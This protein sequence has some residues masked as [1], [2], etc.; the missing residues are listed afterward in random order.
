MHASLFTILHKRDF[1]LL[2]ILWEKSDTQ[3]ASQESLR[4]GIQGGLGVKPMGESPLPGLPQEALLES[5]R[6]DPVYLVGD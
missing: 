3:V 1:V 4:A 6:L 5:S 2:S